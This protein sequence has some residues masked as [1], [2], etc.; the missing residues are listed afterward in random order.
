M[1]LLISSIKQ[2]LITNYQSL[3]KKL[4]RTKQ[5][6][7]LLKM[8]LKKIDSSLFIDQSYFNNDGAH[9]Y[10]IFQPICRT[11]TTFSAFQ[12]QSQNRNLKD[13]QMKKF[14]LLIQKIQF[15]LQNCYGINLK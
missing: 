1:I 9:L 12:T 6:M 3:M 13:C 2:T 5:N 14:N 10:L 4:I 15:F 11:I 8:N 7:Y